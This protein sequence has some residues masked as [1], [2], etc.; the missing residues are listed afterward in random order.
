MKA[1][2]V[3]VGLLVNMALF[4]LSPLQTQEALVGGKQITLFLEPVTAEPEAVDQRQTNS[5][6][7]SVAAVELAGNLKDSLQPFN[8][9]PHGSNSNRRNILRL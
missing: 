4:V 2:P 3:F 6:Q 8:V 1:F 5:F 9:A 7:S